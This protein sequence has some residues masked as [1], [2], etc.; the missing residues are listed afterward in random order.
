MVARP[1]LRVE[2]EREYP[3]VSSHLGVFVYPILV[4]IDVRWHFGNSDRALVALEEAYLD[5]RDQIEVTL[6]DNAD[7][8]EGE[9]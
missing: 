1:E 7:T 8:N 5:A 3:Q 9:S 2:V 4:E 6:K